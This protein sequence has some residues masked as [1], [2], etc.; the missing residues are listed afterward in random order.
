MLNIAIIALINVQKVY[1]KYF[2]TP[3]QE[4]ISELKHLFITYHRQNL[5][6]FNRLFCAPVDF[7]Q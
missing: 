1:T 4:K 3:N 5:L 7:I 6:T 2:V